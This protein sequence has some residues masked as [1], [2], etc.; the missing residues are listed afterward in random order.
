MK[1]AYLHSEPGTRIDIRI[2]GRMLTVSNEGGEAL[3]GE[4]IFERF[5]Q[6]SKKEGSTGLGLALVRAVANYYALEVGYRFENGRHVFSVTW[7]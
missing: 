1:N 7:P 3:D 2:E 6:G 5:Y 4:R